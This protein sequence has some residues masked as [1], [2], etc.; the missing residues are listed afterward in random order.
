MDDALLCPLVYD[1]WTER[2][3]FRLRETVDPNFVNGDRNL[4]HIGGTIKVVVVVCCRD[5]SLMDVDS[6]IKGRNAPTSMHCENING[7]TVIS[8]TAAPLWTT[9]PG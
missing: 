9:T 3:T 5:I 4:S 8:E 2:K 7:L 1:W 6:K